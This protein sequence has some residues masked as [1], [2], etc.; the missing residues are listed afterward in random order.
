[1]TVKMRKG[2]KFADI[3][4]VPECIKNAQ[5]EGWSIVEEAPKIEKVEDAPVTTEKKKGRK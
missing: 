5:K 2:D 4:N 3:A 1:M